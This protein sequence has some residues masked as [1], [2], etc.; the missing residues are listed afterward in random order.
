[1][2]R[3]KPD[4]GPRSRFIPAEVSGKKNSKYL[5][6]Q[7]IFVMFSESS[8]KYNKILSK[9][10]SKQ[11]NTVRVDISLPAKSSPKAQD[12]T[13]YFSADLIYTNDVP[14]PKEPIYTKVHE[15]NS[16]TAS[17]RSR[18]KPDRNMDVSE[19]VVS[20]SLVR[21]QTR[22]KYIHHKNPVLKHEYK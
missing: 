17:L 4:E 18:F 15:V 14:K 13:I 8:K 10:R 19:D 2:K 12:N 6:R 1:M 16:L 21:R 20:P 22:T 5:R 9:L 11:V 7:G 3:Q